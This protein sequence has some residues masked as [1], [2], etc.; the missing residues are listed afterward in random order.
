MNVL[1]VAEQHAGAI[2]KATLHALGAGRELA[3]RTGGQVA[4]ALL[5]HGVAAL[6]D[7]LAAHG[8]DV[9]LADAPALEHPLAEACAPVVAGI[10]SALGATYV[11]AAATAFG[12][13]LLPR[14]AAHLDAGM[15]TEVLG[16]AGEGSGVTFRRPMWAGNV[17]AE[18]EISTPVKVFTVRPTEFAPAAPGARAEVRRVPV[19][20][21][22]AA[23]KTR[24]LGFEAV[25][26]ARPELTEA[27][28][29]VAGGR[30]TRGDFGPL[31]AL[32]DDLGAAVGASR[33]AVDAGWVPNDWQVGQT[34]KVVA[35]ELYVAAGIS[36]AIQHLAGMKGSKV[37][38]AVNKDPEAPIFQLADY[39]LVDDLFK[40]VPGLRAKLAASR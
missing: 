20:V 2:R 6:A 29:I 38:V 11:G 14:V 13:D 32:A 28:A 27:R 12:K 7:E 15:A 16:F 25:V 40:A 19:T 36:G 23:L 35:P 8:S 3:R 34:G 26:S 21:D 17:L 39:G 22:P 31:E 30:G 1:I 10:A 37:I 9:H 5:G 24:H 4:V 33:A 18:V